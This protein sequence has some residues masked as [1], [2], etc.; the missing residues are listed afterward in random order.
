MGEKRV[1]FG[2]EYLAVPIKDISATILLPQLENS[3]LGS[4]PSSSLPGWLLYLHLHLLSVLLSSTQQS[5]VTVSGEGNGTPLQ[6]SC[7]ENP[8]DGGAWQAAGHGVDKSWTRLSDFIFTFSLSCN[9][10]G[11]GNPLQCSCLEN[12]RDGGAWWAAVYGV[13]QS[14]TQLK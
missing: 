4:L 5:S 11:N 7:L 14:R 3:T 12:P 10:E 13:A 1:N 8:M 9:G 2:C 6:Y